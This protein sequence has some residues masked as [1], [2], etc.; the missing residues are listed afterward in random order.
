MRIEPFVILISTKT[1]FRKKIIE[2]FYDVIS[3]QSSNNTPLPS[4]EKIP[5]KRP[6]PILPLLMNED[7]EVEVEV[8]ES[9]AVPL[10]AGDEGVS[11]VNQSQP[12]VAPRGPATR[13]PSNLEVPE[14]VDPEV[15]RELPSFMQAEILEMSGGGLGSFGAR[16]DEFDEEALGDLPLDLRMV[17]YW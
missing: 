2:E 8:E 12:D 9:E 15:F 6:P 1:L 11:T 7:E 14:G 16:Y 13:Q 5:V 3:Y 10:D 4:K 17:R